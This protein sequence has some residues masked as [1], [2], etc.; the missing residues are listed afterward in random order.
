[1]TDPADRKT[2]ADR[3]QYPHALGCRFTANVRTRF[4]PRDWTH[5][6]AAIFA[7]GRIR[8]QLPLTQCRPVSIAAAI[9]TRPPG[10][11]SQS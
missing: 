10:Q 7:I 4:I 5:E 9:M 8:Q 11:S 6:D 1:M 3:R 2:G